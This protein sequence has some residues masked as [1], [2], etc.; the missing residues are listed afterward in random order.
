MLVMHRRSSDSTR[1][2]RC[3]RRLRPIKWCNTINFSSTRIQLHALTHSM[4]A[5]VIF[6]VFFLQKYSLSLRPKY[7]YK[8]TIIELQISPSTSMHA[9]TAFCVFFSKIQ[10]YPHDLNI[11]IKKPSY[12]YKL[13]PQSKLLKIWIRG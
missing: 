6:C 7:Y 8:K 10:L 11:I 3:K 13:T 9:S 4:H 5:S 2:T 1:H 12:N